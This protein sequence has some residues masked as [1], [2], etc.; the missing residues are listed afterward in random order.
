MHLWVSVMVNGILLLKSFWPNVRKNCPSDREKVLK[1]E[2]E[3]KKKKKILRSL[4]QFIQTL[5]GQN[6]FW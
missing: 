5:K 1:I 6:N 3:G 4:E 2:A